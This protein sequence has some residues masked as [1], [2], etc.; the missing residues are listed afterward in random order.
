MSST[1]IARLQYP[2]IF[3]YYI[4]H[5]YIYEGAY[6]TVKAVNAMEVIEA[7]NAMEVIE[8]V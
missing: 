1:N 3:Y 6:D 2:H 7:V 5:K 4:L 8:A